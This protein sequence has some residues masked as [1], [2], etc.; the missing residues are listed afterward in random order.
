MTVSYHMS[1]E[2]SSI[3]ACAP[4]RLHSIANASAKS[5]MW[6]HANIVTLSSFPILRH[7]LTT[8]LTN[9][10]TTIY[11]HIKKNTV[12]VLAYFSLLILCAR[13]YGCYGEP[14]KRVCGK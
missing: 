10:G 3:R 8:L 4:V 2:E 7:V 1:S 5:S 6:R 11:H 12:C 9:A 13:F 14:K